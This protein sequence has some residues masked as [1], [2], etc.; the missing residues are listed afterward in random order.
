MPLTYAFTSIPDT[1]TDPDS[2]V[3]TGLMT[4]LNH[5][6]IHNYEWIGKDYTPASNHNH[7][8]VNSSLITLTGAS[9]LRSHFHEI[10][11][12]FMY[13]TSWLTD[14]SNPYWTSSGTPTTVT[15]TN[16]H[17][18]LFDDGTDILTG[19]GIFRIEMIK[20]ILEFRMK[21]GTAG[22]S[23]GTGNRMGIRGSTRG[24]DFINA[25]VADKVRC[26]TR[27]SGGTQNTDVTVG[28]AGVDDWHTYKIDLTST[29]QTLFYVDGTLVATHATAVPDAQDISVELAGDTTVDMWVDRVKLYAT[30]EASDSTA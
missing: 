27:G 22:T 26:Q 4:G 29:T 16:A 3:T 30:Q 14:A 8:G 23:W 10:F 19:K 2:P 13:A 1:D 5:N 25:G 15:G 28:G 18:A 6:A 24:A 9:L 20:L 17:Y 12:H 11:D 7:D 21:I